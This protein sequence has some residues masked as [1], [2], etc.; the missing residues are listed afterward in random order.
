MVFFPILPYFIDVD[1]RSQESELSCI[2]ALELAIL[3][4]STTVIFEFAIVPTV[5]YI[6]LFIL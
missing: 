2:C 5:W 6:L 1:V 4:F 3:S